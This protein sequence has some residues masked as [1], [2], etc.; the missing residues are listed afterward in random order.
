MV[1]SESIQAR[2]AGANTVPL[3]MG[4]VWESSG[5]GKE[6]AGAHFNGKIDS[7]RIFAAALGPEQLASTGSQTESMRWLP[8]VAAWD[9]AVDIQSR[10]GIDISGNGLHGHTVNMPMRG[11]TGYRWTGKKSS[12]KTAPGEYGA[13]HFH[14]D[15][16]DD[17]EWDADLEFQVPTSLDSG[18]YAARLRAGE[19]EDYL[20]FVVRPQKGTAGA[21]IAYLFPTFNY[22]AYAN[23]KS[24]IPALLSLYDHHSDGSGVAYAS[25]LRPLLDIRPKIVNHYSTTGERYP[26]HFSADLYLVD[27]MEARGHDYD[28]I[29][30][31]DLHLEGAALLDPYRVVVTGSH[32]EYWSQQ[33][34][35]ALQR[36][37]QDGGRFM[38]LGGNG[39]YWVT[40]QSPEE[41]HIIE[42]RR[43]GGTRSWSASAGEYYHS[44]TGELGGLWRARGRPPQKMVGV[45]FT[46]Q[47]WTEE[48]GCGLN[49]PYRRQPGSFDPRAAFIFEGIGGDETI[50]GFP[51]LGLGPGAAGD[52]LDR[53][54][55]D[56]G[57]PAHT[58]LLASAT[59]FS[60]D[61]Q[62]VVEEVRAIHSTL[63]QTPNPDY[64][65]D[66]NSSEIWAQKKVRSS[67]I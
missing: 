13:I 17:A 55:F 46:S 16:L 56:L 41:P 32:P 7:P 2:K 18:V 22:L 25:R 64:A 27:W 29:T 10:R 4:A 42:V 36:Y 39:F 15:D 60:E 54:D 49:R 59:G 14:D 48:G 57:T 28:V 34:L 65:R 62:P 33:M 38:Y 24:G 45:G 51:S 50:S 3:V 47:G 37:L 12:F 61:Y 44:T 35:D 11:A 1:V 9:F 19:H 67:L 26:V 40:S 58:L 20:P 30:D 31:G 66:L 53:M 6:N 23:Y 8:L 21:R 63:T 43:W 52:E 5:E